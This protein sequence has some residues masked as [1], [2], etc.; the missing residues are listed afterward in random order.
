MKVQKYLYDIANSLIRIL[1]AL[2]VAGIYL[3]SLFSTSFIG[4]ITLEDGS[5]LGTGLYVADKPW[6]HILILLVVVAAGLLLYRG[7]RYWRAKRPNG[8][9]VKTAFYCLS[10]ITLCMG[11]LLVVATQMAPVSDPNK[12]YRIALQWREQDFSSYAEGGYLFRYPFQTGIVLFYYLLSFV[13]G[14]DNY[15]GLQFVNAIALMMIYFF[16]ARLALCFWRREKAVSVIAFAALILWSPLSFYV[17]YLYGILPGMALSLAAIYC[18]V[19]Y[20]ETR[21]YRYV[22]PAVL[23]MGTATVLKTNCLIWMIAVICF[24]L[25]DVLAELAKGKKKTDRKWLGSLCFVILLIAGTI[26]CNKACDRAAEYISGY[27]K[28]EGMAMISW[29][30]MGLSE[31]PGGPGNYNGYIGD[32]FVRCHYDREQIN[33]AGREDIQKI[34]TQMSQHFVEEAVPFFA[35]KNAYQWNDPSFGALNYNTGR[36]SAIDMP[37]YIDRLFN[38][39]GRFLFFTVMNYVQ[40][41][42]LL[43]F[44][45]Y[46]LLDWNS[47]NIWELTGAVVFLGGYL[48][49]FVWESSASYTLPYFVLI[50]PY[51]VKGFADLIRRLDKTV[52]GVCGSEDRKGFLG[53][54]FK[55]YR[56]GGAG[57]LAAAVL[58]LLFTRTDSFYRTI[59]LDDGE[60]AAAQ[61]Y[62]Q[63]DE[64]DHQSERSPQI[65]SADS[66]GYR[67]LSPYLADDRTIA[68]KDGGLELVPIVISE[69]E[70]GYERAA[71]VQDIGNKVSI[72][73]KS[74]GMTIRFRSN[75]QVLAVDKRGGVTPVLT[76]YV[77]DNMNLYYEPSELLYYWNI[78]AAEGGGYHITIDDMALACRN[79]E[80]LLE[81]ISESDEQRWI[82]QQ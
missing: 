45:L 20:A 37:E 26:A 32:V 82:F 31:A 59:A 70:G 13:L 52:R 78:S 29:V 5:K 3:Q 34:L 2:I 51:S 54:L 42:F 71:E 49:H 53:V 43:G 75:E 14:I 74:E 40:T 41:L 24:L 18:V 47:R 39:E 7:Y 76:T 33:Q 19:R 48:F 65:V 64:A 10:M 35:R 81:S 30:V 61:F 11:V 23:C 69:D 16:L 50:I 68:M 22:L 12:I 15:I 25:Y 46:L 66:G 1:A 38:G 4:V 63:K 60:E 28:P 57:I 17:T 55:K 56:R 62:Y 8:V 77:D 44:F 21:R 27:E 73:K 79:G 58:F 67:Y 6:K 9:S 36:T 72:Q 80:L